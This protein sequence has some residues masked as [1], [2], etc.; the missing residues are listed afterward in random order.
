MSIIMRVERIVLHPQRI[1][2]HVCLRAVLCTSFLQNGGIFSSISGAYKR[3]S[4][5]SFMPD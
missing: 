2:L 5:Y 3:T 1:V 4:A